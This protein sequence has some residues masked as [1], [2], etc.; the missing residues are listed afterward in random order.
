MLAPWPTRPW[1]LLLAHQ[2][3]V[4][5]HQGPDGEDVRGVNPGAN[6]LEPDLVV[7]LDHHVLLRGLVARRIGVGVEGHVGGDRVTGDEAGEGADLSEQSDLVD[8]GHHRVQDLALER[9]GNVV[10]MKKRSSLQDNSPEHDGFVFDRIEDKSLP[11]LYQASPYTVYCGHS[12]H[13]SI[14][15]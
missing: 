4:I 12:Y 7:L 1:T 3:Q 9:P 2:T 8:L 14:F 10:F 5:V 6:D 11:R 13:E 15:S